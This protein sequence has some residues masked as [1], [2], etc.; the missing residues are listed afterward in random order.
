MAEDREASLFAWIMGG[1]LITTV[2]VAAVI[3]STHAPALHPRKVPAPSAVGVAAP[4]RSPPPPPP[5]PLPRAPVQAPPTMQ[6]AVQDGPPAGS[7]W[8]CVVNGERTFSDAPCGAHSSVRQLSELNLMD[9]A[10]FPPA[11]YV[12]YD[13]RYTTSVADQYTPDVGNDS[14]PNPDVV[15]IQRNLKLR[16]DLP[17]YLR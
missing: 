9:S 15:L 14:Y 1:V 12:G 7:V 3:A 11:P 17:I 6:P 10:Q 5:P 16:R 8:E 4:A 13:P 2:A